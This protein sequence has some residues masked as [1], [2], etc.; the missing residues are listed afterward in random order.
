MGPD[1]L[2]I[3]AM[4]AGTSWLHH[5]LG[6][7]PGVWMPPVKELHYLAGNPKDRLR[8]RLLLVR[9]V[10]RRALYLGVR[11]ALRP[12]SA[13]D[14]WRAAWALRFLT[15]PRTERGYASMFPDRPGTVRGELTPTYAVLPEPAIARLAGMNPGLRIVYLLR[16]PVERAWS[17]LKMQVRKGEI[18]FDLAAC[19]PSEREE[20]VRPRQ[21]AHGDYVGNLERWGRHF[22]PEQIHVE[23]F[24]RLA[25]DPAGLL[26]DVC[27]FLGLDDHEIRVPPD[28]DRPCNAGD[29]SSMPE[30]TARFLAG[31]LG[32]SIEE[33][34]R[35][36]ANEHT[37]RWRS[38]CAARC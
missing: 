8:S 24:D 9:P 20:L 14:R 12:W 6:Q 38:S 11:S 13:D 2:C 27:R 1:F 37:A 31:T 35:V 10:H 28:V 26:R 21:L 3:G 5:A 30:A 23:F 19:G 34:H 18:A 29:T 7:Q 17:D 15:F 16:D 33:L 25:D 32:P 36:F 22:P 4:K